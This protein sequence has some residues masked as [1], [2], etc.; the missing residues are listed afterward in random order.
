MDKVFEAGKEV[1]GEDAFEVSNSESEEEQRQK[2]KKMKKLRGSQGKKHRSPS[3]SSS[4]NSGSDSG[5][6]DDN[7]DDES[8]DDDRKKKKG[9]GKKG[10]E[11]RTKKVVVKDE[12]RGETD[13]IKELTRKLHSMNVA[14]INYAVCFA[15]L[16]MIVP[17]VT[18]LMPSPWSQLSVPVVTTAAAPMYQ[19]QANMSY[20]QQGYRPCLNWNACPAPQG[21][22]SNS[23]PPQCF[24]CHGVG[25]I[26]CYCQVA[27]EY[28]RSGCVV[29]D[30]GMFKFPDGK[31]VPHWEKGIKEAVDKHAKQQGSANTTPTA[32]GNYIRCIPVPEVKSCAAIV[33]VEDKESEKEV[34]GTGMTAVVGG[35]FQ[36]EEEEVIL[37]GFEKMEQ[38]SAEGLAYMMRSKKTPEKATKMDEE[39]GGCDEGRKKKNIMSGEQPK[40]SSDKILKELTGKG[41]EG[42]KEKTINREVRSDKTNT[43]RYTVTG[44]SERAEARG[45]T[46]DF[47]SRPTPLP[48]TFTYESK[49]A[50]SDAH[51][52]MYNRIASTIVPNITVANLLSLS[53]EL[54]R[55]V[56]NNAHTQHVPNPAAQMKSGAATMLFA[57]T[58]CNNIPLEY[59]IPLQEIRVQVAG[60]D[61]DPLLDEGSEIVVVR[62]D[63]W[64]ELSMG[65]I[66]KK[67]MMM[68]EMVNRAKEAMEGCAEFLEIKVDGMKTWA[69]AYIAPHALFRL[70]LGRPLQKSVLLRKMEDESGV[71]MKVHD[72]KNRENV[73]V[74]RTKERR[75]AGR[76]VMMYHC[77]EDIEGAWKREQVQSPLS[78]RKD[79]A[80]PG[81]TALM[82][83]LLV[84]TFD[85]NPTNH[86][87]AYKKVVN[88]IHPVSTTMPEYAKVRRQFSE[89]PLKTLSDVPLHPPDFT[90]G[91]CLTKERLDKL[92]VMEDDFLWLEERK[93]VAVV[94]KNNEMG[95]AWTSGNLDG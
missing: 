3:S 28:L 44:K 31:H 88:K 62:K 90:P 67:W 83:F 40:K 75:P 8:S 57:E 85:F 23:G 94:L 46:E 36:D 73:R 7:S 50:N 24:F 17:S 19:L 12:K 61:E 27:E 42:E 18:A 49:A 25:H 16:T 38:W 22:P 21:P 41:V 87:L 82:D 47:L 66:N 74:I 11:I 45:E 52:Q 80:L 91:A 95:L 1:Y 6:S 5:D 72:L 54:Q 71:Y 93:I 76:S 89:D 60:K 81:H 53:S 43:I 86:V 4:D 32:A 26:V 59:S 10:P 39:Q 29:Y 79:L 92:R 70:L 69:H 13:D 37:A 30:Q 20:D 15:K 34:T 51:H 68:M 48:P 84:S 64:E 65:L 33:E 2:G 78:I 55:E 14:N 35:T 77:V 56:V 63:L 9:K 58:A